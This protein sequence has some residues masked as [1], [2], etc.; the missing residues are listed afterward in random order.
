MDDIARTLAIKN[1]LIQ[2][3][4]TPGFGFMKQIAQNVVAQ[5]VQDALDAEDGTGEQKRLKAK[6]LQKGFEDLFNVIEN[7]KAFEAPDTTAD[8][9]ETVELN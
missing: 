6:A 2:T 1:A 5:A 7:T 9:F 4:S 8:E 3:T